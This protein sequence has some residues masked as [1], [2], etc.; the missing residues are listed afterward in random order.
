MIVVG[1]FESARQIWPVCH[2]A[3]VL[4]Y[5]QFEPA[6]QST[7]RSAEVPP[8]GHAL[9]ACWFWFLVRRFSCP[10]GVSANCVV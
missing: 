6:T 4:L 10:H 8:S 9:S 3:V 7:S 2:F 1:E 5:L